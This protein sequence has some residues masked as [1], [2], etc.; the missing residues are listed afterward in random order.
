MSDKTEKAVKNALIIGGTSGGYVSGG[1]PTW[2]IQKEKKKVKPRQKLR[3]KI[4]NPTLSLRLL[5]HRLLLYRRLA[6]G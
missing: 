6:N 2:L 4:P 3:F 1:F 5:I